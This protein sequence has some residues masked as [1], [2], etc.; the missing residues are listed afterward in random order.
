MVKVNFK[1]WESISS[2]RFSQDFSLLT[3]S[4]GYA[5]K[6]A[7]VYN[8]TFNTVIV[9]PENTLPK[10]IG[11]KLDEMVWNEFVESSLK[12]DQVDSHPA[13]NIAWP[14]TKSPYISD[15]ESELASTG[16]KGA[17][18]KAELISQLKSRFVNRANS[19]RKL[20]QGK[21][22]PIFI[23][24]AKSLQQFKCPFEC[25]KYLVLVIESGT[26]YFKDT[27]RQRYQGLKIED[28]VESPIFHFLTN[29][30]HRTEKPYRNN[31]DPALLFS[32]P[33]LREEVL[34]RKIQHDYLNAEGVTRT[35]LSDF[36]YAVVQT[37]KNVLIH[38][39][40]MNF[41]DKAIFFPYHFKRSHLRSRGMELPTS[42]KI[43]PLREWLINTV[44]PEEKRFN[45]THYTSFQALMYL[46]PVSFDDISDI[47]EDFFLQVTIEKRNNQE[48]NTSVGSFYAGYRILFEVLEQ[49]ETFMTTVG[50][51]RFPRNLLSFHNAKRVANSRTSRRNKNLQWA[52]DKIDTVLHKQLSGWAGEKGNLRSMGK[53]NTFI[54]WILAHNA[55]ENN[56]PIRSLEDI[57]AYDI[58][59]PQKTNDKASFY[60]FICKSTNSLGKNLA[61]NTLKIQWATVN[62]IFD[63]WID[64][65]LIATGTKPAKPI[66]PTKDMFPA[67]KETVTNRIPMDSALH[68]IV[69][70]VATGEDYAFAKTLK[71]QLAKIY[72]Y[73][74]EQYEVVFNPQIA[75]ILHLIL[76]IP[77]RGHS[78]R[79]LDE[80]LL[81]DE[82]WDIESGCYVKNTCH[83][84]NF[85]Y[86]DGKRHVQRHGKT[87][88]KFS[89][90]R[91][92]NDSL[93]LYI[94]TNKTKMSHL[95]KK[96][97]TGY[98]IDWP[99]NTGVERIDA[100]YEIIL[101]QQE[102]NKI[103]S[104]VER[105]V[106]VKTLDE[107]SGKYSLG[108]WDK[109]PY[110]VPLFR[111]A[112]GSSVSSMIYLDDKRFSQRDGLYLPPS[113]DSVRQYFY[114]VMKEAERRFKE[115]YPAYKNHCIAF[116]AD[117]KC[118]Y[119]VHTLRVQGISDLL[120][121][122]V[123]LE[124]VQA[125]VGHAT[126]V[127]TI[128][129]HKIRQSEFRKIVTNAVRKGGKSSINESD[130][131]DYDDELISITDISN[132]FSFPEM[133]DNSFDISGE[134]S[135]KRPLVLN[136]GVCFSYNCNEGGIKIKLTGRG[137]SA[138]IAPVDGGFRRCGNCRFWRS[139]PRFL[140]EQIYYLNQVGL[141]LKELIEKRKTLIIKAQTVYGDESI[142][143]P[144]S[145]SLRYSKHCDDVNTVIAQRAAELERRQA[146]MN[147]S[148]A[149]LAESGDLDEGEV[150]T[151]FL[152]VID[153]FEVGT[154]EKLQLSKFDAM[155][156]I[157]LQG[158][159]LGL[160]GDEISIEKR[161]LEQFYNK[162]SD[163]FS[164]T[165]P[166]LYV[167][168]SSVKRAAMLI[169][170]KETVGALGRT[171]TD[172][173]FDDPRALLD[174]LD[175]PQ[176]EALAKT[177]N[178][179]NAS[180]LR[181]Q[182]E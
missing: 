143:D 103:Y 61:L 77:L 13:V 121:N 112:T 30:S 129:Y 152:S 180:T 52:V 154:P 18:L 109:L 35:A 122:G 26:T 141:E 57:G 53:L 168:S 20:N 60:Y 81:D 39:L 87:G 101:A 2:Y 105:A 133:E 94:N 181:E 79:W 19:A 63:Y 9:K 4:M 1:H 156:E 37:V 24:W 147:A 17:S 120:D 86:E 90:S 138:V 7:V 111:T 174:Q 70:E 3:R 97:H 54:D 176:L 167:P 72:N 76:L 118:F 45:K 123:S 98:K 151:T 11:E 46:G 58:Y 164:D 125:I 171:F 139:G 106:P 89:K 29:C 92:G 155:M 56:R 88:V 71:G 127:M 179:H 126:E 49:D 85:L 134:T 55:D 182:L 31:L 165:N 6:R 66:P 140:L 43:N 136:G 83:L 162:L 15:I 51:I 145:L 148:L 117:G 135:K 73:Q 104:P 124:V 28:V 64:N 157:N 44:L 10:N 146:M 172:E 25:I 137:A 144:E 114:A 100:V 163:Q 59:N 160:N 102:W 62:Q 169:K 116:G 132:T 108:D 5:S 12:F 75:R 34:R 115:R 68:D 173:E 67:A 27:L 99:Y 153:D 110:F 38:L 150:E 119:D 128:Y 8:A 74:S 65:T 23:D 41:I 93:S 130:Y 113:P 96:G 177:L 95:Q 161:Q 22:K 84:A 175:Q 40:E 91:Q 82:I 166:F 107:Q 33:N 131:L 36:L 48:Y 14:F 50:G 158:T 16:L 47:P 42:A 78:A 21:F 80:G 32:A 178:N 142:E 170:L 69:L 149:K 159:V